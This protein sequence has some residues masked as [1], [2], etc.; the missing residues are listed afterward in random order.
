MGGEERSSKDS[1]TGGVAFENTPMLA[2]D[3][4][5]E[6]EGHTSS[7]VSASEA[8]EVVSIRNTLLPGNFISGFDRIGRPVSADALRE[9]VGKPNHLLRIDFPKLKR[10]GNLTIEDITKRLEQLNPEGQLEFLKRRINLRRDV[11]NELRNKYQIGI[12]DFYSWIGEQGKRLGSF[13]LVEKVGD[14]VNIGFD[15]L[16]D[17]MLPAISNCFTK[18]AEYFLDKCKDQ[19]WKASL[20]DVKVQQF[21]YGHL[22]EGPKNVYMVDVGMESINYVDDRPIEPERIAYSKTN[23]AYYQVR[24]VQDI[25]KFLE[26]RNEGVAFPEL[27][28]A[29]ESIAHETGDI[30]MR[31]TSAIF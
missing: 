9:V 29:L 23:H 12:P 14:A 4:T 3:D 5:G 31:T 18:L 27:K 7:V 1:D 16:S 22:R 28:H 24:H 20:K 19:D 17:E 8:P 25:I 6:E 21:V 15:D 2:K 10:E 13:T 11:F 26:E 30:M